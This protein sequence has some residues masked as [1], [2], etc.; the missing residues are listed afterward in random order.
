MDYSPRARARE[1]RSKNMVDKCVS[2]VPPQLTS[3]L[4]SQD[5]A[6]RYSTVLA[7]F[8]TGYL[9]PQHT[10]ELGEA[11]VSPLSEISEVEKKLKYIRKTLN[12]KSDGDLPIRRWIQR[13]GPLNECANHIFKD[14]TMEN[15]PF[16]VDTG[17][18]DFSW[19]EGPDLIDKTPTFT[20][21]A[22]EEFG[23]VLHKKWAFGRTVQRFVRS[24]TENSE[25]N[26]GLVTEPVVLAVPAGS[27]EKFFKL[28]GN[29]RAVGGGLVFS[30]RFVVVNLTTSF[31]GATGCPVSKVA[32]V[33]GGMNPEDDASKYVDLRMPEH[34]P[35]IFFLAND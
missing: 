25:Q 11:N 16:W 33:V 10:I 5:E 1:G 31:V 28:F 18:P 35:S 14:T 21:E 30:G 19:C 32:V 6:D 23:F 4:E 29:R 26:A 17:I 15:L 34:D 24:K 27:D 22:V 7:A 3:L 9:T 20:F 2:L 8:F 13:Y 12:L